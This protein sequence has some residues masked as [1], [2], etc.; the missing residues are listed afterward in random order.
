M[1]AYPQITK[2]NMELT[3]M[4]VFWSPHASRKDCTTPVASPGV[5]TATAHGYSDGDRVVFTTDGA[6]PTGIIPF[7][8]YVVANAAANTFEVEEL[9]IPGASINFTVATSGQSVVQKEVDL[10]GTLDNVVISAKYTKADIK[11]DQFGETILDRRVKGIELNVTTALTEIRNKDNWTVAFP[12]ITRL[13]TGG[14]AVLWETKIGEKDTDLTGFLR[15]HPMSE[16]N[17]V[18]TYDFF[19]YEA[20]ASSESSITY[21]PTEQAKLQVVWTILPD[22]TVVPARFFKHGDIGATA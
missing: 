2:S 17:D 6:L 20:V 8:P 18:L 15:L 4:Q 22:D 12:N 13:S 14:E 19:M 9:G 16:D 1:S 3:P 7:K 21:G 11:A 5:V 10:G